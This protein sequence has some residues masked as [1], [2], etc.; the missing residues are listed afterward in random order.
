[1]NPVARFLP[2]ITN[3]LSYSYVNLERILGVSVLYI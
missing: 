2:Y 3:V 1:M